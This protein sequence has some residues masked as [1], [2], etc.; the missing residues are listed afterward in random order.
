MADQHEYPIILAHGIARFDFLRDSLMRRLQLFLAD[1]SFAPDRSHYFK[2]IASHLRKHGFETYHSSV[3]FASGVDVRAKELSQEILRILQECGK[4]K[5]HIIGHSMGG[6]DARH[7]IVHEDMAGK[8]ASLTTIGTP[9]LG[10]SFAGWGL[11]H[12]GSAIIKALHHSLNLEG[13][14][15]LTAQER[16]KFNESARNSEAANE[17]VYQTYAG[18]QSLE[19]TFGPLKPS[20][21]IIDAAEGPNDGLVSVTSQRWVASII[22]NDGSV[23]NVAQHDFP[24]AADH[25]NQIGWWDLDELANIKWWRLNAL[26][27][28]RRYEIAIRNAYLKIAREVSGER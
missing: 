13:F 5:V 14:L 7:M 10:T 17:V 4:Q 9:H 20:W 12:G 15:T 21:K 6:L 19:L 26:Q 23:K 16:K 24:V 3:S 1:I 28:K 25:L 18:A 2:N 22:G 8:V 11:A 27:E